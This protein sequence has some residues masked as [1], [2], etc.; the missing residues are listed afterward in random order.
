MKT[1][2]MLLIISQGAIAQ[3]DILNKYVQQGINDNESIHQQNFE[4]QRSLYSLKEATGLFFPN[5]SLEGSY[6]DDRGGRTIDLPI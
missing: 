3:G 4:L 2:L 1:I 6:V 5:V